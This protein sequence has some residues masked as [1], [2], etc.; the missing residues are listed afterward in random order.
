MHNCAAIGYKLISS[1]I[2]EKWGKQGTH[3]IGIKED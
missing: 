1:Y 2:R 3:G